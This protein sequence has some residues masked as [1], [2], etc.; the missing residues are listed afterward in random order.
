MSIGGTRG[1]EGKPRVTVLIPALNEAATIAATVRAVK[2]TGLVDEVIVIDDAS[3]DGTGR[4][5]EEAGARVLRRAARGGKGGALNAGLAEAR[6]E[7]IVALDADIGESASEVRHLIAPVLAGQADLT[8][9]R[10]PRARRKGGFGLVKGLARWGIRRLTGLEME[11][12]LSGQRAMRRAVIE[13]LGGFASGFG[14]EVGMTIDAAR[15]GF[16]V[17]EVP[18]RMSHRETGRDLAG[19]LHRGRQFLHVVRELLRRMGGGAAE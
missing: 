7:V 16:R 15:R 14:V 10:F 3:E 5:A 4:L 2:A 9:A 19:F 18:V 13:D 1:A 17:R 8:I 6:G 12:P 11:S